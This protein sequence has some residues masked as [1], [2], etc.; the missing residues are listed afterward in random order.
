VPLDPS[1]RDFAK[2][3]VRLTLDEGGQIDPA[4]ADAVLGALRGH[5]PRVLRAILKA[6][7]HYL[8]IEDRRGCLAVECAGAID[9]AALESLRAGLAKKYRRA[10]RLEVRDNPALIA[11]LRL[12][13]ADDIYECSVAG[14]LHALSNAL[15]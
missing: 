13:V 10:L 8:E 14:R 11:G 2:K 5:K 4:R 1:H 3:L 15:A 7:L 12:A 6:Y 9:P